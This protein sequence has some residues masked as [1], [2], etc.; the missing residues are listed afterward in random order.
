[1]NARY[2]E[3]LAG[4]APTPLQFSLLNVAPRTFT[5]YQLLNVAYH[6]LRSNNVVNLQI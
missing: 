5:P 2:S 6:E 1:M 3:M 4:T